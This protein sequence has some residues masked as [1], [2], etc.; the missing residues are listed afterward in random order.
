MLTDF[1]D[2]FPKWKSHFK[3]SNFKRAIRTNCLAKQLTLVF[4][5]SVSLSEPKSRSAKFLSNSKFLFYGIY[6]EN[7][8]S[9]S[10]INLECHKLDGMMA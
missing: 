10:L 6:Y 2:D 5:K 7:W 8:Y 9:Y 4:W 3:T 1:Y